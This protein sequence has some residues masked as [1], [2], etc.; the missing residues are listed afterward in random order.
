MMV[1]PIAGDRRRVIRG[2]R[3]SADVRLSSPMCVAARL[4]STITERA[5]MVGPLDARL[6]HSDGG[7][8]EEASARGLPPRRTFA[9]R[10]PARYPRNAVVRAV[11]M[12]GCEAV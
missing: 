6:V 7:R 2:E 1:E 11:L 4:G 9:G 12:R 3:V 10:T 5:T 8:S